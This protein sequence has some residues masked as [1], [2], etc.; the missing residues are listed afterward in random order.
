MDA[1]IQAVAAELRRVLGPSLS[2]RQVRTLAI[3]F[4]L[5]GLGIRFVS[6]KPCSNGL[7][8]IHL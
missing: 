8:L 7:M 2:F 1:L 6:A 5:V 4:V 3:E